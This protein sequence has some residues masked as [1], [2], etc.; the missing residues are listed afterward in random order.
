MEFKK[1]WKKDLL[2]FFFCYKTCLVYWQDQG[3]LLVRLKTPENLRKNLKFPRISRDS[4]NNPIEINNNNFWIDWEGPLGIKI[5]IK[6]G[7]GYLDKNLKKTEFFGLEE[8]KKEMDGS[9][10]SG[11]PRQREKNYWHFWASFL[12]LSLFIIFITF[13]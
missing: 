7:R 10:P 13:V 11:D 9:I 6:R 1:I 8:E 12:L 4:S 3:F 2:W 5:L